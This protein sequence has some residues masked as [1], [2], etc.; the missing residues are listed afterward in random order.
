MAELMATQLKTMGTA[1]I[2]LSTRWAHENF[3]LWRQI[4]ESLRDDI[5]LSHHNTLKV[6]DGVP[7][8]FFVKCAVNS[9]QI[10]WLFFVHLSSYADLFQLRKRALRVQ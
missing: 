9:E 4:S 1:S 8:L 7:S 6:P 5:F 10:V 3:K 2:F